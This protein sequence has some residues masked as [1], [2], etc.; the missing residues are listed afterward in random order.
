MKWMIVFAKVVGTYLVASSLLHFW[1]FPEPLPPADDRP[2]IGDRVELPAG[3]AFTFLMT[4]A[5]SPGELMRAEWEGRTPPD[6]AGGAGA[7][8]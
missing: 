5:E 2:R 3:S 6:D 1:I 8:Q 4:G 7:V